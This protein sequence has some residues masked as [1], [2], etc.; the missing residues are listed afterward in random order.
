ML[1]RSRNGSAPALQIVERDDA[2]TWM[3]RRMLRATCRPLEARAVV[4]LYSRRLQLQ[5][6]LTTQV[7]HWLEEHLQPRGV[8]VVLWTADDRPQRDEDVLGR[9]VPEG[10]FEREQRIIRSD[11]AAD[12]RIRL[13]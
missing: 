13:S 9:E 6:R 4:E 12:L 5:E 7:A 8:G 10:V 1:N 2:W 11:L 3:R